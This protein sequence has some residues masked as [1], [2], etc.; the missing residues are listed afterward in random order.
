MNR[1]SF[2]G[3]S[4]SSIAVAQT[5]FAQTPVT[6]SDPD[7]V[8]LRARE[9][10]AML[11]NVSPVALLEALETSTVAGTDPTLAAIPWQ[12][13]GD[14]DLY[15]SL[16]GVIIAQ[17]GANLNSSE[18][19]DFGGYIVYESAEIVYHEL[20]HKLGDAFDSPSMTNSMGGTNFWVMESGDMQIAVGRIGYVILLSLQNDDGTQKVD[21]INHLHTVATSLQ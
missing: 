4:I 5:T 19:E 3:A 8:D 14:T 11:E 9:I 2:V 12:D 16:G 21:L 13:F 10:V 6:S 17:E 1:R 20:I 15:S 18:T 7:A